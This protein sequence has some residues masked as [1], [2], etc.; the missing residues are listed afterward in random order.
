MDPSLKQRLLGAAVLIALAVIFVPMFLSPSAPPTVGEM[1]R[2]PIEI[3]AAPEREFQTQVMPTLPEPT[4]RIAS[5]DTA[6]AAPAEIATPLAEA[7]PAAAPATAKAPQPTVA[8]SAQATPPVAAS[9]AAGRAARQ[10]WFVHLGVYAEAANA[11]KLVSRLKQANFA[12]FSEATSHQGR[13]MQRVRVGPFEDRAAAEAARLRVRKVDPAVQSS[14]VETAADLAADAPADALGNT[15][16]GGWAVQVGA[17]KTQEDA[18]KLRGRLQV[19]GFAAWVDKVD[20]DGVTLWRVRA[21]PEVER[22]A[23][24]KL[25]DGIKD[26]LKLDGIIVAL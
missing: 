18:N 6:S 15:R 10:S 3:P 5:V 11:E 9:A 1:R 19:A 17:L 22:D 20:A 14:V 21:G 12:A 4:D 7:P 23:A 16:A 2:A 13:T 8:E 24:G 26:K 25:R